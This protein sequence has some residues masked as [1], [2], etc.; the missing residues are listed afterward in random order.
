MKLL[1]LGRFFLRA[2]LRR[3]GSLVATNSKALVA[4]CYNIH[5]YTKV[6]ND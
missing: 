3:I 1:L 5:V 6:R 2:V 4:D